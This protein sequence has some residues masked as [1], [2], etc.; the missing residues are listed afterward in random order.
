MVQ[1]VLRVKGGMKK[2]EEALTAIRTHLL[3]AEIQ[4]L[5]E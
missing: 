1:F 5:E 3:G 4:P 2:A